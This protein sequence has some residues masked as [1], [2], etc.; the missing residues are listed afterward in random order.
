MSEEAAPQL[1]F[2]EP[3]SGLN[4]TWDGKTPEI[5]VSRIDLAQPVGVVDRIKVEGTVGIRN[6]TVTRWMQWFELV[7]RNYIRLSGEVA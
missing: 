7:C 3:D 4:F 6:A 2:Y 5:E 1:S